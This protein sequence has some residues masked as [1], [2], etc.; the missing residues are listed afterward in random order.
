M[1]TTKIN[2][3]V[4]LSRNYDKVSLG[5]LDEPVDYE[6]EA[7]FKAKV[8]GRFKL[9]RALVLDEFVEKPQTEAESTPTTPQMATQPQITFLQELGYKGKIEGL[10]KAE[11]SEQIKLLKTNY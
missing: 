9:L 1:K 7:D 11:A 6:D 4:S 5:L 10:T 2:I 3:E 8:K